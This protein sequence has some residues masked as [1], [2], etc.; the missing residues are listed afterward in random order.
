MCSYCWLRSLLE[1]QPKKL[2]PVSSKFA[3]IPA[4]VYQDKSKNFS[5]QY[6]RKEPKLETT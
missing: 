4:H 6:Y 1:K 3:Y 2:L 5:D